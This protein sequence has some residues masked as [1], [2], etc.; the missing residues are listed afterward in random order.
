ME[1]FSVIAVPTPT[2]KEQM[3]SFFKATSINL[4]LTLL[5]LTLGLFSAADASAQGRA[6]GLELLRYSDL[7]AL[8]ENEKPSQDLQQRLTELLS[9][10]DLNPNCRSSAT[11]IGSLMAILD[12]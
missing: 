2:R 12:S 4:T 9:A 7:V 10:H 5:A 6:S 11:L 8:Y 1:I 3:R